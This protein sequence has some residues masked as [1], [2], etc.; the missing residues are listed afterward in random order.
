MNSFSFFRSTKQYSCA[1]F[2]NENETLEDA[3]KIK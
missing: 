2:K 1:Y 3:Q